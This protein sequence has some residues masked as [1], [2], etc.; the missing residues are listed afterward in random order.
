MNAHPDEE[1]LVRCE[2]TKGPFTMKLIRNWSPNGY[3]RAI[4]L[5]Q[6]RFF[7]GSHFFRVVPGFLVQFGISYSRDPVLQGMAN[8]PIPD[9]PKKDPRIFFELGTVAFAGGG[10]DSRTSQMFISYGR[11]SAFG[12][13]LWETP[14]GNVVEGIENVLNFYSYGDMPPWGDGPVQEKIH[15]NPDYIE[16]E[17]PLTDK[18]VQC[19]V[20]RTVKAAS[21]D[22]SARILHKEDHVSDEEEFHKHRDEDE[23]LREAA[24]HNH[25][26][27]AAEMD[28]ATKHH[29]GST[30]SRGVGQ[31]EEVAN[32]FAIGAFA[33][34]ALLILAMLAYLFRSQKKVASK[35]Q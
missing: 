25:M 14:V 5:F 1:A 8:K 34:A 32:P 29:H 26:H 35:K 23:E 30:S 31:S 15:N 6:K 2:T 22:A 3:D 19:K 27:R 4:E 7:D 28:A 10:V 20:T 12:T 11:N 16:R 18:F 24:R 9:D 33:V 17:F 21:T 13:Q